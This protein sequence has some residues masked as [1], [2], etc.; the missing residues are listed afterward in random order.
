MTTIYTLIDPRKRDEFRY[1]G[2]T[3]QK[4]SKRLSGHLYDALKRTKKHSHRLHWLR[5]LIKEGVKPEIRTIERVD[6]DKENEREI[7]WIAKYRE[8]GHNLTNATKGGEGVDF[9]PEVRKKISQSMSGTNHPNYGKRGPGTPM[10]GKT[11]SEELK[12]KMKEHWSGENNPKYHKGTTIE[13]ENNP[14][15]GQKHS[16]DAKRRM[17]EK[18]KGRSMSVETRQKISKAMKDRWVARKLSSQKPL[19]NHSGFL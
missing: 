4:P 12:K 16:E 15:Y 3:I 19:D 1:V 13:G 5:K 18:A 10:Y 6:R 9:T 14:F 11:H 8:A 7:Y 17:S 2:K